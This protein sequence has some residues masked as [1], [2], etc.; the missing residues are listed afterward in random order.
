QSPA[1]ALKPNIEA[2]LCVA[3]GKSTISDALREILK[4]TDN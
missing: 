1:P 3:K 4:E 2:M